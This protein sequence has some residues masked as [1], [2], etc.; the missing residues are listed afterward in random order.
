[1]LKTANAAIAA[2]ILYCL[3]VMIGAFP[4]RSHE[5]P[6]GWAYDAACCSDKDCRQLADGD[7]SALADGYHIASKGWTIGYGSDLIKPSLDEHYH[8]CEGTMY[9]TSPMTTGAAKSEPFP[10][11]L[12]APS[13][14][15]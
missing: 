3:F 13:P 7:V 6:A 1:M 2:A 15:F 11:C 4:A 14:A 10:R 5:A 12:Y 8:L 9:T